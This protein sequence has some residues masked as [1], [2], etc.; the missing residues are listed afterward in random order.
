MTKP[1]F[2]VEVQIQNADG[3]HMRPAMQF[4]DMASE[5]E[6]DIF[7]SNGE[8]RVNGKSIMEMT[9]LAATAGTCL[10]IEAEGA[11]ASDAIA[12]LRELVEEKLFD[13][14]AKG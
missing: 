11:D 5:F 14:P 4:V 8:T 12:A 2:E 1:V 6:S 3:L 7:V 10:K 9:M 13:E